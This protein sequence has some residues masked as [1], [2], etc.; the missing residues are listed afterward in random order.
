MKPKRIFLSILVCIILGCAKENVIQNDNNKEAIT[1]A[2]ENDERPFYYYSG[3]K[4]F[5]TER[6][7]KMLIQLAPN[8]SKEQFQAIANSKIAP[9]SKKLICR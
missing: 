3:E 7:D 2:Q 8:T 1:R 6:T 5:L 4:I 9:L